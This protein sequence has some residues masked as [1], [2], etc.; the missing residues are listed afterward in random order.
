MRIYLLIALLITGGASVEAKCRRAHRIVMVP[1]QCS[2]VPP[3]ANVKAADATTLGTWYISTALSD[4]TPATA[5]RRYQQQSSFVTGYVTP[6]N[7]HTFNEY[8]AVALLLFWLLIFV[9]L[10][11]LSLCGLNRVW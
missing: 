6:Q 5:S 2:T 1:C 4:I 7:R 3:A 11:L 9:R 8:L 10:L